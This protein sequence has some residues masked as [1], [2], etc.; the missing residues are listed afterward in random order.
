M[1]TCCIFNPLTL[2]ISS[3]LLTSYKNGGRYVGLNV[4]VNLIKSKT[5]EFRKSPLAD[6]P[7]ARH[8][9]VEKLVG[10]IIYHAIS[11]NFAQE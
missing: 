6:A 4:K 5:I 8:G 2:I 3:S 9:A 1:T 10:A 7:M 11:N